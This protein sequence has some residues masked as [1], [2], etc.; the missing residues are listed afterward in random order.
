MDN[1]SDLSLTSEALKVKSEICEIIRDKSMDVYDRIQHILEMRNNTAEEIWSLVPGS[2]ELDLILL[3]VLAERHFIYNLAGEHAEILF[4]D[5]AVSEENFDPASD[6]EILARLDALGDPYKSE[7]FRIWEK[8]K[9]S[10][11]P[12]DPLS[13]KQHAL[14]DL[15]AMEKSFAYHRKISSNKIDINQLK[16]IQ[17]GVRETL[18]LPEI[19]FLERIAGRNVDS[20]NMPVYFM[21]EYNMNYTEVTKKLFT[22]GYLRFSNPAESVMYG[23]MRLLRCLAKEKGLKA[24]G[25]KAEIIQRILNNYTNEEL[26]ALSLPVRY[27][28]TDS[29]KQV[30]HDNQ[31]LIRYYLTSANHNWATDEEVIKN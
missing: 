24:G 25:K 6:K 8:R 14:L 29:G 26:S 20:P 31:A 4:G 21:F 15:D 18:S 11:S 19:R 1:N 5:G 22:S 2:H 17:I 13:L 3:K 28:P 16:N 30:L 7:F 12:E 10:Y 9:A 27:V 23:D